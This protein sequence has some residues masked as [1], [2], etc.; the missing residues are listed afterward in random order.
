MK[1]Y[2]HTTQDCSVYENVGTDN[3]YCEKFDIYI[4]KGLI[5]NSK[6]W[7]LIPSVEVGKVYKFGNWMMLIKEFIDNKI[8]KAIGFN[9]HNK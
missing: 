7:E 6:D 5:E 9:G 2:N 3:Y 4:H 8:V 1:K